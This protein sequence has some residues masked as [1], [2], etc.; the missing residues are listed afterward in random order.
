MAAKSLKPFRFGK[1]VLAFV[2]TR[3]SGNLSL[4][5]GGPRSI[6]LLNRKRL[7]KTLNIPVSCLISADQVHKNKVAV[8]KHL[9][10]SLKS[11]DAMVADI[12]GICLMLTTADCAP[13]LFYDP[14][15]KVIGAAHAGWRGTALKIA[16]KTVRTMRKKFGSKPKDILV[17]MG[18]SIGPCCYA[19]GPDVSKEF[20]KSGR[21]HLDLRLKNKDQLIRLGI[22][23]KNIYICRECTMCHRDKYFSARASKGAAGRFGTGI[24]LIKS[25]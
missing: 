24:M 18:P 8:I 15:R 3:R 17:V 20:G 14:V 19:V 23:S 4:F 16:Q 11:T 9:P 1:G 10:V 21:V 6:V 5:S 7:A 22:P 12:P 13:L 25:A 2:T